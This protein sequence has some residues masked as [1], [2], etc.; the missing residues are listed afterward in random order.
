[1]SSEEGVK[2]CVFGKHVNGQSEKT[3]ENDVAFLPDSANNH[4]QLME[5]SWTSHLDL[6]GGGAP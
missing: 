4:H 3:Q 5:M 2:I 1:M 6:P